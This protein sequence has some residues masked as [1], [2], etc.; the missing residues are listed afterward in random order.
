MKT[1]Q[2]LTFA[3]LGLALLA[4]PALAVGPLDEPTGDHY[5][6][7]H[8]ELSP[9]AYKQVLAEAK[10]KGMRPVDVE[11]RGGKSRT[12][13]L[14]L[15]ANPEQR[16]Y[17]MYTTLSSAE[18]GKHWRKN[19][20]EGWRLIDQETYLI[21]KKRYYAGI[22]IRNT[23]GYSWTSNRGMT[24]LGFAQRNKVLRKKGYQLLEFDGWVHK[25][26]QRYSAVWVANPERTQWIYRGPMLEETFAAEWKALD[27]RRYRLH[28]L[29]AW[30]LGGKTWFAGV[31]VPTGEHPRIAA[32]WGDSLQAFSNRWA[33]L[34]DRGYRSTDLEDWG[35]SGDRRYGGLW[36]A[37]SRHFDWSGRAAVDAE[38]EA[39]MET[40][41][42]P[43]MSIVIYEKG[44]VV[45]ER[46]MGLADVETGR[47]AHSRTV[48]RLASISKAVTAALAYRLAEEDPS[49]VL[50]TERLLVPDGRTCAAD[51]QCSS[52][53]DA[54]CDTAA[55]ECRSPYAPTL[56]QLLQC[57]GRVPHYGGHVQKKGVNLVVGTKKLYTSAWDPFAEFVL[58]KPL[59]AAQVGDN[60]EYSTASYTVAAAVLEER[61]GTSFCSLVEREFGD[62]LGLETLVCENR[63]SPS[64]HRAQIYKTT[65]KKASEKLNLSWKYAGGG[66]EA[67]AWE[68]ARFG[69]LLLEDEVVSSSSRAAMFAP[70][71]PRPLTSAKSY[72][73]GWWRRV[74]SVPAGQV[75][76]INKNGDQTGAASDLGLLPS[77]RISIAVTTNAQ[78]TSPAGMVQRI[79]A[80]LTSEP[81]IPN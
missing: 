29:E 56:L 8:Q 32:G 27:E 70:P 28:D 2:L 37:N 39:F 7:S 68:L 54:V 51:S 23:E 30:Q 35:S 58:P 18:Y 81:A 65:G 62:E 73:A 80:A 16:K 50:T 55:G 74:L 17:Q 69:S 25:G 22:W 59:L 31:W 76:Y 46:G 36:V 60:Y 13:S 48:Y 71:W 26:R 57:Q 77:R 6:E 49:L 20:K 67:S 15:R 1:G 34:R 38:V 3:L 10:A 79:A 61:F 53:R 72:A 40:T 5:F 78:S 63:S 44:Q 12:Y 64:R 66:L 9:E 33:R 75:L 24:E 41:K 52:V 14:V 47:T 45:Y 11:I 21:G 4:R 42:A 43:G 19:R